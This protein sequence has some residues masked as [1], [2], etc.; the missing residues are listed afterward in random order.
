MIKQTKQQTPK[1]TVD[2]SVTIAQVSSSKVS[3]PK[4]S[5]GFKYSENEV[6][7]ILKAKHESH[8]VKHAEDM[9]RHWTTSKE[10]TLLIK[11][12]RREKHVYDD[13][14]FDFKLVKDKKRSKK[15]YHHMLRIINKVHQ[16]YRLYGSDYQFG[17]EDLSQYKGLTLFD[18]S[19]QFKD[20][21]SRDI[22]QNY[23]VVM[24][25]TRDVLKW[26]FVMFCY[27]DL[28]GVSHFLRHE[29]D[30]DY[31]QPLLQWCDELDRCLTE[32]KEEI[33]ERDVIDEKIDESLT[34]FTPLDDLT[35][36]QFVSFLKFPHCKFIA[37]DVKTLI[38]TF[39]EI[40]STS[41]SGYE[42]YL[43]ASAMQM[44]G[45]ATAFADLTTSSKYV[46]TVYPSMRDFQKVV[47][48]T[49]SSP[50]LRLKFQ[51]AWKTMVNFSALYVGLLIKAFK[52]Y[53]EVSAYGKTYLGKLTAA[54]DKLLLNF[55]NAKDTLSKNII[56]KGTD[57]FNYVQKLI[58]DLH[59]K[60]P[61]IEQ[62]FNWAEFVMVL[63]SLLYQPQTMQSAFVLLYTYCRRYINRADSAAVSALCTG[64]GAAIMRFKTR[65]GKRKTKKTS[66]IQHEDWEETISGLGSNI[67]FVLTSS[68]AQSIIVFMTTLCAYQQ[69]PK[70]VAK[71]IYEFV[72]KP[73]D[74]LTIPKA[75]QAGLEM[76]AK[77]MKV[78]R[79]I[80]WE[81]V[82]ICDALFQGDP[83]TAAI[84]KT[85]ELMVWRDKLYDGLPVPG[86]KSQN[87]FY[88]EAQA[89]LKLFEKLKET[90]R[91]GSSEFN[92][93]HKYHLQ[94]ITVIA[95]IDLKVSASNRIT[96]L[97]IV[98]EGPPH[99][100]KSTMINYVAY[101]MSTVM[102]VEYD[103]NL[104]YHR[105]ITSE[106]WD[107]YN[108][109]SHPFIHYSELGTTHK[110][111]AAKQG[112][113]ATEELTS[114]VDS[115]TYPVNVAFENKGKVFCRPVMVIAD[116]NTVELNL[117][118]LVNNP[119]AFK[120]RMLC[121]R[122]WPKP[123]FANQY[124][125]LDAAKAIG[126]PNMMDMWTYDLY[127][128]E[129]MSS[130]LANRVDDLKDS[131][132]HTFTDTLKSIMVQHI[133]RQSDM[134]HNRTND[135][136]KNY[137]SDRNEYLGLDAML[138]PDID[139]KVDHEDDDYS[140]FVHAIEQPVSDGELLHN[141]DAVLGMINRPR[142][143]IVSQ[144]RDYCSA[145][146]RA[147]F[148]C[149]YACVM[150]YRYKL[151][152]YI[153]RGHWFSF[154]NCL[155]VLLFARGYVSLVNFILM[156][157]ILWFTY[158][159]FK[160]AMLNEVRGMLLEDL[161]NNAHFAWQK[162][163]EFFYKQ[164]NYAPRWFDAITLMIAGVSAYALIHSLSKNKPDD[165]DEEAE[166]QFPYSD[167]STA[168]IN[169]VE[170]KVN[171][172]CV[173]KRIKN[174]QLSVWN[175]ILSRPP[176]L[177]TGTVEELEKKILRNRF[178]VVS[179][180]DTKASRTYV[181]G[182]QGNYALVNTHFI[183]KYECPFELRLFQSED[184][185]SA[186]TSS[187][188][189]SNDIVDIGQDVSI[190][191]LSS[192]QFTDILK[193]FGTHTTWPTVAKARIDYQD[194]NCTIVPGINIREN[195]TL[196]PA[197]QY[198]WDDHKVG[199][200]G[201]PLI[202]GVGKGACIVGLHSAGAKDL[203]CPASYAG[204][205]NQ[206]MIKNGLS[207]IRGNTKLIDIMDECESDFEY[208][209]P[210]KKSTFFHLNLHNLQFY[211]KHPGN[212]LIDQKSKLVR[213]VF[214]KNQFLDMLFY[215]VNGFVRSTV[216]EKPLM[217]PK[218][219][220]G[221][222][223]SPYNIGIENINKNRKPLDR[224]VLNFVIDKIVNRVVDGLHKDGITKLAP[225][226]VHEAINGVADDPFI[227]RMNASTSA[228][229]GRPGKKRD[230]FIYLDKDQSQAFAN[231]LIAKDIADVLDHYESNMSSRSIRKVQLKDEP[232][233]QDKVAKGKTRL[234]YSASTAGVAV[235]RQFVGPILSLMVSHP[236][237]FCTSIGI[238]MHTEYHDMMKEL[239]DFSDIAMECDYSSFDQMMPYDIGWASASVTFEIAKRMGYNEDALK[240]LKGVLTDAL[241]P[242]IEM[243]KDVFCAPGLKPSG[244]GYT[245]EDNSIRHLIML[246]Y[247]WYKNAA[248]KDLEFFDN[249][250]P[251]TYGDDLLAAIKRAIAHIWNNKIYADLCQEYYGIKCTPAVKG[252]EFAEH[253]PLYATQFL[254]RTALFKEDLNRYVA[255]LDL[256]SIYKSLE[257]YMPSQA[258]LAD[259]E[260][261]SGSLS[262]A[263]R[264]M[265]FHLN[266][267]SYTQFR[268]TIVQRF[269]AAYP[270]INVEYCAK[271]FL[272]YEEL[273]QYYL[274]KIYGKS[275]FPSN[276]QPESSKEEDISVFE[277][278]SER[279]RTKTISKNPNLRSNL[280]RIPH[281][282]ERTSESHYMQ[283]KN[284][285]SVLKEEYK[286]AVFELDSVPAPVPGLS[287]QA[288]TKE[289]S[290]TTNF[291]FRRLVDA[292]V[293]AKEKVRSLQMTIEMIESSLVALSR[294]VQV[295][296]AEM[297]S[298]E[299]SSS[300]MDMHENV[301]DVVG[302]EDIKTDA[303]WVTYNPTFTDTPMELNEFLSRPVQISTFSTAPGAY[304]AATLDPWSLYLNQPSVRAKLKNYSFL[305]A[306][307]NIKVVVSGTPFH[308]LQAIVSY[309]P[310]PVANRVAERY[311]NSGWT[312]AAYRS[313]RITWLSQA[314]GCKVIQVRDNQ[315]IHISVPYVHVVP[316]VSLWKRNQTT[317]LTAAQGY[318]SV[319]DLGKLIIESPVPL[320]DCA[321]TPTDVSWYV[322]AFLTDV[323][324]G[325][326]TK[327]VVEITS[328]SDERDIGP[329]EAFA[330]SAKQ[331]ADS[332]TSVPWL[333]PYAKASSI[334][335]GALTRISAF[336]GWSYPTMNNEPMRM[337]NEPYRNAANVIGYDLGQRLTLDP[338][339]ELTVDPRVGG[340]ADDEL[341]IS[342]IA[343]RQSYFTNFT[344]SLSSASTSP[345]FKMP[346]YP[347]LVRQEGL[348]TEVQQPTALAMTCE[349]FSY[350]RG[351]ISIRFD[352][353]CTQFHRGKLA[354]V[355]EPNVGQN[356]L[357]DSTG[358]S[359][360]K[361]H[362]FVLDLQEAQTIE[363]C[364]DWAAARA[365]LTCGGY[366][367]W[368]GG[369]SA[370]QERFN[371]YV[372]VFPMTKLQSPDAGDIYVNVFVSGKDMH[373]NYFSSNLPQLSWESEQIDDYTCV[374][375]N[376]TGSSEAHIH[377][378]HF[379]EG[380]ASF[381]P[382][383]KRFSLTAIPSTTT[384]LTVGQV[385]NMQVPLYPALLPSRTSGV[386]TLEA[387]LFSFLRTAFLGMRGGM[388]FRIAMRYV[389]LGVLS[390]IRIF[391]DY[392]SS[393]F[394]TSTITVATLPTHPQ[395][396]T[397]NFVP[398]TNGGIEFE[399]PFYTNLL[400]VAANES[401]D[402]DSSSVPLE[403]NRSF[404]VQIDGEPNSTGPATKLEC[405]IY[406]ATAEDFS[407]IRFLG[408]PPVRF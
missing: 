262:S 154:L 390:N 123:E 350:W 288:L 313:R 117:D 186:F 384:D 325:C 216:F 196:S 151:F 355:F 194:V 37:E 178:R 221:E 292:Y 71:R 354:F 245:A 44:V 4:V 135:N 133:S 29:D 101:L 187:I 377:D 111:R 159:N 207:L 84:A 7:G 104:I 311:V 137:G 108:P 168:K 403:F 172:G 80:V 55:N 399:V 190:V 150:A 374:T 206:Q 166:T 171:A 180:K 81:G 88:V 218:K 331:V 34:R 235:S 161:R 323:Q 162:F 397:V 352:V 60:F 146:T 316:M 85:Q 392:V 366:T 15:S 33:R 78:F 228:G 360:N 10:R 63:Y 188:L 156:M 347:G 140:E 175:D 23:E 329:V 169:E 260:Q 339:Q 94:L 259:W 387:N 293:E 125:L 328:E 297:T 333:N 381:R 16:I 126:G 90:K 42:R 174:E 119:G 284:F 401:C 75:I 389:K 257:W 280:V 223:I 396:G 264:E 308:A 5:Y 26:Y 402:I 165:I 189:S 344:W 8:K 105:V 53:R 277:V 220:N 43:Y 398:Y 348:A 181:L 289:E 362:V 261:V 233:D 41:T 100:G 319:S 361:Q 193:H 248:T 50:T 2:S 310:L 19:L 225:L 1:K 276:V 393:T 346:I 24:S 201:T 99:I 345:L 379:G 115:I 256:N 132:I 364:F 400:F 98:V 273:L 109:V 52:T 388:R 141:R 358:L 128:F 334:A 28:Q 378:F 287:T 147:T 148:Q 170:T 164:R 303:G 56:Q 103:P 227:R 114:V 138:N 66:G 394:P 239:E 35:A 307:M 202:A 32:W 199:K 49:V 279:E 275:D 234:F 356:V 38:K 112:D 305:R 386:G 212:V 274:D 48:N 173:L 252:D 27:F 136:F 59:E 157:I 106:Y 118:V 322:Y 367:L 62:L 145:F 359:L 167:T 158:D 31:A 76:I 295:E 67:D 315:P 64:F 217:M 271:N 82:P 363:L 376:P 385:Y 46:K 96:P 160:T 247:A 371:G 93:I 338:K 83:L 97:F 369:V 121:I 232:R 383:L 13:V 230:Y 341:S 110:D 282:I 296:S 185:M 219:I 102:N 294:V 249:V 304:A 130:K 349:P 365:W 70:D 229:F 301:L 87:S 127:H 77:L 17:M 373:Y 375:I 353:I 72:G 74:K 163:S 107:C 183:R 129:P 144:T 253:L 238:D 242:Y 258:G 211:G 241:F 205:I 357:I 134:I 337:K 281:L 25:E 263:L 283:L 6:R 321:S 342:S 327:T 265:F 210:I 204:L 380:V 20:E 335:L 268:D 73:S 224:N 406:T 176:N 215:D 22:I 40:Y 184:D 143:S 270:F 407:F 222:W 131:D 340:V 231:A 382:L 197:Y 116:T 298:G 47:E 192:R 286:E 179:V 330:T 61:Y 113:P 155:I 372:S 244:D 343:G 255:V 395:R 269:V 306:T 272:R 21:D 198:N 370:D 209:D 54:K 332:L 65:K 226:T 124:G 302:Q 14:D 243:N 300:V 89:L 139:E 208:E 11:A 200:C 153:L 404:T 336:F 236:D 203:S 405:Q 51:I 152:S 251:R 267:S 240:H 69:F 254:K 312:G 18:L 317:V 92:T 195:S 326:P 30:E 250:K 79:L 68:L 122:P 177:H 391:N 3:S 278:G 57:F 408:A 45:R 182:L 318:D 91:P 12:A 213:T 324:L 86:M 285:L 9:V 309:V 214:S 36:E 368:N 120:R 191:R 299:V 320:T 266:S 95:E 314:T 39:L 149:V 290:Y 142:A 291:E 58:K 246:M 351:K 237:L